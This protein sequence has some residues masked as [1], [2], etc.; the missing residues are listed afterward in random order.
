MVAGQIVQF[1][2]WERHMC[3]GEIKAVARDKS[4]LLV[5]YVKGGVKINETIVEKQ[6]ASYGSVK[7]AK[8]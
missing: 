8:E 6:I 1:E 4:W 3:E 2:N 7:A 5:T